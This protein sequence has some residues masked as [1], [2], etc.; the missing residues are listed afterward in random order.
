MKYKKVIKIILGAIIFITLPSLLLYAFLYLKY[1]E[2]MPQGISG[3]K[4]DALAHKMLSA[5]DYEAFNNTDYIEWSYQK[6]RHYKW[7]KEKQICEVQWKE[8]R[9]ILNLEDNSQHSAYVHG[10]NFQGELAD[11]IIQKAYNHFQ[12]DSFW[13]VAPYKIFDE[14]NI[15]KVINKNDESALLVTYN[16]DKSK[17]DSTYLW[18][19]DNSGKPVAFKMWKSGLPING[20]EATWNDWQTTESGAQFPTFHKVMFFGFEIDG[21]KATQA[22]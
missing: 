20:I 18:L 19:L 8:Y 6:K 3:E 16:D 1:N 11:D 10:F 12:E 2:P 4:A 17:E 13:L 22:L 21:L 14:G 15:R 5:L 7:Y 9:V